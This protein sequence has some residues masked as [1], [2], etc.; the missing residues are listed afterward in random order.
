MIRRP[1]VGMKV[2]ILCYKMSTYRGLD[3]N[4]VQLSSFDA[5]LCDKGTIIEIRKSVPRAHQPKVYT[6]QYDPPNWG[7]HEFL[8]TEHLEE[9]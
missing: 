7:T 2:R 8:G 6:V 4:K 9:A 5:T 3:D 1:V